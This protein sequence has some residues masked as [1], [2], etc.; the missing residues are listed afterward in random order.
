MTPRQAAALIGCSA[1]HA[2]NLIKSRKLQA[3]QVISHSGQTEWDVTA[4]AVK[5][6][7]LIPLPSRG[8]P[9]GRPRSKT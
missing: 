1:G 8:W 5:K 7:L 3:K 4:S 6:F 2:R 9:R